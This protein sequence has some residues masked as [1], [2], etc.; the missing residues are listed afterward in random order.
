MSDTKNLL[1]KQKDNAK[2]S[3]EK[4]RNEAD[5]FHSDVMKNKRASDHFGLTDCEG[6]LFNKKNEEKAKEKSKRGSFQL[7][8]ADKLDQV[9]Q[10]PIPHKLK[11]VHNKILQHSGYVEPRALPARFER[12]MDDMEALYPHFNEVNEYLRQRLRLYSLQKNPV[13]HFGS[14]VL[15]DGPAGVGK[16]S[17]L[18]ELSQKFDT[19][20]Y[21]L[22][23]ARATNGFDLTGMSA[24]WN[25]GDY[26]RLHELLFNLECPNPMIMLDEVDKSETDSNHP[27]TKVLYGLL[28]QNNARFFKDEFVKVPMDASLVNW[29]GTC[30]DVDRLDAPLRDRFEVLSVRA[31]TTDDLQTIIPNLYKNIVS[32]HQLDDVF[33]KDLNSHVV[34]QLAMSDGISLRRINAALE[35]ALSNAAH[36]RKSKSKSVRRIRLQ[37]DDILMIKAE[38]SAESHPIGFIWG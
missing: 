38:R 2:Q 7:F 13:L 30:N 15:L 6:D 14:N 16:S 3:A 10:D 33:A 19:L 22:D 4:K 23:C 17:Y 25:G 32:S 31:P 26:G 35:I 29:F 1:T 18:F 37:A 28:E 11:D 24:K 34:E 9:I 5:K 21:S 20:F 8:D 12:I 36:R 27:I